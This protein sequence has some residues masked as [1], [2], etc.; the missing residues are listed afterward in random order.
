MLNEVRK[1]GEITVD[2]E[3]VLVN[4]DGLTAYLNRNEMN[5]K[6]KKKEGI[7]YS[8]E[9]SRFN[10]SMHFYSPRACELLREVLS[11]P[12]PRSLRLRHILSSVV[13]APA[14]SIKPPAETG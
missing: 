1:K 3:A 8:E 2:A 12:H 13:K 5:N 11:L 14:T 4:F 10:L 9:T 7:R 6:A